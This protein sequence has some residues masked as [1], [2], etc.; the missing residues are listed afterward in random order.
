M[1]VVRLLP[2]Q[3]LVPAL[4]RF[5]LHEV[6]LLEPLRLAGRVV[7]VLLAPPPLLPRPH[8]PRHRL[9]AQA[10][11]RQERPEVV[12]ALLFME[13]QPPLG[14]LL[15]LLLVFVPAVLA[16]SAHR[17]LS[18]RLR[19]LLVFPVLR[20]APRLRLLQV[21]LPEPP[22]LLPGLL[23]ALVLLA[24]PVLHLPVG[25]VKRVLAELPKVEL[26]PARR[27]HLPLGK[28]T[29]LDGVNQ[30]LEGQQK[31]QPL[32]TPVM[33]AEQLPTKSRLGRAVGEVEQPDVFMEPFDDAT[34]QKVVVKL[35]QPRVPL[36]EQLEDD[37][38]C[39]AQR[40]T[41]HAEQLWRL[42][43]RGLAVPLGV[44]VPLLPLPLLE[45]HEVPG[46]PLG[47]GVPDA[48]HEPPREARGVAGEQLQPGVVGLLPPVV[49]LPVLPPLGVPPLARHAVP[50]L[51]ADA[52]LLVGPFAVPVVPPPL[53]VAERPP[54]VA[55]RVPH[56]VQERR[57]VEER[58]RPL[59]LVRH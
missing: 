48:G 32:R 24:P 4:V 49:S 23:L 59:V 33:S 2:P 19:Q 29:E 21:L 34:P 1:L 50:K 9:A 52:L 18:A 7:L 15:P 38:D 37:A 14:H 31:R 25:A 53:V 8:P 6:V 10:Q 16:R 13:H 3:L 39:V 55:L 28:A 56:E 47:A 12:R 57:T 40:P 41:V 27:L 26:A 17:L 20:L 43:L 58:L 5:P 46:A 54:P 35:P 45:P 11:A 44:V 30:L 42:E 51:L 22:V 36:A